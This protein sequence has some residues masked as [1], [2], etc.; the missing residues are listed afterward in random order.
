MTATAHTQLFQQSSTLSSYPASLPLPPLRRLV[1]LS[2][3]TLEA[4]TKPGDLLGEAADVSLIVNLPSS[5]SPNANTHD[6]SAIPLSDPTVAASR[7]RTPRGMSKE[8][9]V[10]ESAKLNEP[11][12]IG[13]SFREQRRAAA[14]C[15]KRNLL[16]HPLIYTRAFVSLFISSPLN[17]S[18]GSPSRAYKRAQA[19]RRR[20]RAKEKRKLETETRRVASMARRAK[21]EESEGGAAGGAS[22]GFADAT[23]DG[24]VGGLGRGRVRKVEVVAKEVVGEKEKASSGAEGDEAVP[25]EDAT[26]PTPPVQVEVATVT[27]ETNNR[28]NKLPNTNDNFQA[29]TQKEKVV[30]PNRPRLILSDKP[31][32]DG[33]PPGELA[34]S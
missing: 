12:V 16:P 17:Y 6:R 5:T 19:L 22:R 27:S 25:F 29:E 11:T 15:S 28:D 32:E 9:A 1:P 26:V 30:P 21:Q 31:L 18:T 23:V 33:R 14:T 2:P 13:R 4:T 24:V 3:H 8:G 34:A 7:R 10:V 20:E